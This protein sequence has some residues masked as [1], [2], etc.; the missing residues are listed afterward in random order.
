MWDSPMRLR[1]LGRGEGDTVT[2]R[3]FDCSSSYM[4]CVCRSVAI[5]VC[6]ALRWL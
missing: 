5:S 4:T 3:I 6:Y 2:G 1:S